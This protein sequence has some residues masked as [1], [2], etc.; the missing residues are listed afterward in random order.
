MDFS[1]SASKRT[2]KRLSGRFFVFRGGVEASPRI[3]IFLQPS[4]V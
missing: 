4:G 1:V 3:S 2:I